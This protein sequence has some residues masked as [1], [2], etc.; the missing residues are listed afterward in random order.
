MGGE[1]GVVTGAVGVDAEVSVAAGGVA[2]WVGGN[3]TGAF[4]L[5]PSSTVNIKHT[6]SK[7]PCFMILFSLSWPTTF[8][9]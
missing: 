1:V 5:Q 3:V 9:R 2:S 8:A 6:S 4:G 7:I